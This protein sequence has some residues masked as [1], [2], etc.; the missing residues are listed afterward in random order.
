MPGGFMAVSAN[1]SIAD[2]GIL[3]ATTPTDADPTIT[4]SPVPSA[5]QCATATG[6][7]LTL[8]WKRV[9]TRQ[10]MESLAKYNPHVVAN[11]PRLLSH[12][13]EQGDRVRPSVA[14]HDAER[15][16]RD[17]RSENFDYGGEGAAFH[18]TTVGNSGAA[19]RTGATMT[20]ISKGPRIPRRLRRRI[21]SPRPN[22]SNIP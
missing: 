6:S 5:L 13:L 1:D 21:S 16:F 3:W 12:L 4:P 10:S 2:T 19:Y 18:E 7:T 20:S 14:L 11:G 8:L 17:D 22:G 15:R 9:N